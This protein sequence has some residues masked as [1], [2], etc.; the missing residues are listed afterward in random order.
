MCFAGRNIHLRSMRVLGWIYKDKRGV[1]KGNGES[2]NRW[3]AGGGAEDGA[4]LYIA[5]N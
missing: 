5:V 3:R 2:L 4:G 1:N